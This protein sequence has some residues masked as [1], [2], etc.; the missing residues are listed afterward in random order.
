[1]S[2]EEEEQQDRPIPNVSAGVTRVLASLAL[3]APDCTSSSGVVLGI[4]LVVG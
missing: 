2:Q 1:M 4:R 3:E